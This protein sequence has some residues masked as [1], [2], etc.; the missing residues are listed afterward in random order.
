MADA[1]L[2]FEQVRYG[3]DGAP[4]LLKEL[5][6]TVAAGECVALVGANGAG[7]STLLRLACGLLAPSEGR[8]SVGGLDTRNARPP[9]LARVAGMMFQEAERQLCRGRVREEVAF[10]SRLAGLPEAEVER[11]TAGALEVTS[12]TA[13]ADAHPFDLNAG[14]RRL[15]TLAALIAQDVPLL[16]LDE[17]TRDF[18][19]AQLALFEGW[20]AREK[21]AG[22]AILLISHD[23]DFVARNCPRVLHLAGGGVVADGPPEQVLHDPAL[24]GDSAGAAP[25]LPA[26]C[27]ALGL[28]PTT[29]AACFDAAWR[30]VLSKSRG[31]A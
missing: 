29:D 8:V 4:P 12:L 9:M 5:S 24:Q 6:L 14:E 22:R 18:D 30:A 28:A 19:A 31:E 16:L 3:W 17:P 25:T 20:L 13:H 2:C 7:K 15:L 27:R 21:S 10:A 1:S 23:Y 11:R 26:L